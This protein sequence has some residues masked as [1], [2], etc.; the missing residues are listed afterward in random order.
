MNGH[1]WSA[2]DIASLRRLVAAGWTDGRIG[3][4]LDRA[5]ETVQRKRAA[6][7]LEPGQ[8]A[9]MTAAVRRLRARRIARGSP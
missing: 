2:D 4:A 1:G 3:E 9:T 8:S 7:R 5:R 6:L